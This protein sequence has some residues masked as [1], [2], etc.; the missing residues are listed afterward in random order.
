MIDDPI[1]E[2][3][4]RLRRE[5]AAQFGNDLRAI[6]RDLKRQEE[7]SEREFRVPPKR[8]VKEPSQPV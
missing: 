8:A 5:Y 2:E 4:R 6:H 1:V 3:I 7:E